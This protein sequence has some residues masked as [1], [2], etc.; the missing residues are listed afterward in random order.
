MNLKDTLNLPNAEFSIPMKANLPQLEPAM[1]AHWDSIGIYEVIQEARKDAE[2]F[3]LHDGPPYTNSPIH[4]GT[5]L[6]KILKDFIIKSHSM[7]GF[8]AP[9]VPGYDNHGL[10]IEQAVMKKLADQKVD[11]DIPMLRKACREHAEYFSNVQT[12]Q[13]KRL[14]VFGMWDNYYTPMR[15]AYGAEIV[16]CFKRLVENGY[17]YRGLRPVLWSPTFRTALADTEIVYD[18]NH[19]STSIFVKFPLVEDKNGLFAGLEDV[20]TVIWTTTPWTIPANLAVAYHPEFTYV[21]V[22]TDRGHLVLLKDLL[23]RTLEKC[24]LTN[25]QTVKEFKGAEIEGTLFKHPVYDR[26][27]LAVLA[28]YV[29]TEDGTGVVH[30][31]PGHGREDF[32]T[33]QKYGL[34]ILCPVDERGV[35]TEEAGEFAGIHFKKCDEV[36]V[37]RLQELGTL[38]FTEPYKHK[39]PLAERDNQPVIFRTTEQWF[40]G[41]DLPFHAD[42]NKTLRQAMLEQIPQVSWFPQTGKVRFTNMIEGRPDW[43]ISRQRPWGIGIP[44]FY[45]KDSGKPVLD[46]AAIEAVANHITANG[47]DSW[48]TDEPSAILPNAYKHP[49]TGETEFVKETDVFDVWFDSACTHIAVLEGNVDPRWK[50]HLPADVFAEGSDQHRGWFN[51]SMVLGM[52]VRAERPFNAVVTHGMITDATGDKMSKRKG[53]TIDPVEASNTY[54]ADILR[55]WAASVNYHN[56]APVSEELLKIAGENY[57]SIRNTLRFLLGNLADYD[58]ADPADLSIID[59][60]VMQSTDRLSVKVAEFLKEYEF[61]QALSAIHNFC[62]NELSRFY[63]DAIKDSMYADGT[64]WPSRRGAQQACLYVLDRLTLLISPFLIHTAEETY[65]K[66]PHINRLQSVHCDTFR[67]PGIV[68]D[69]TVQEHVDTLLAVRG[70]AFIAWEQEKQELGLKNSQDVE[71]H[72]PLSQDEY[73]QLAAFGDQLANLFKMAAVHTFVGDSKMV[74]KPSSYLECARSRVRRPDVELVSL[75]GEQVPLSKRDRKVLGIA[76]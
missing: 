42:Q 76:E 66:I 4:I 21:V 68:F 40:I 8:R 34:Q 26:T 6:N 59:R 33:G 32:Q 71:I 45:G 44:I 5:G 58:P 49:E 13:F 20:G 56:D 10:P 27:S 73:D 15:P 18:E 35:L 46:P 30:T 31:A 37:N 41:I 17:I 53:N 11:Y 50:E 62:V 64:N 19:V 25:H 23:E 39:Y 16:R 51:I 22:K 9:Y 60:W 72:L 54:G 65:A 70:R 29:T 47:S 28:D 55:Y 3:V 63:L 36:V 61:N 48:Y 43:C 24:G 38:L 7:M 1:Q 57:R 74:F 2:S 12:E 75:D 69:Q 14:G 67:K 52:A